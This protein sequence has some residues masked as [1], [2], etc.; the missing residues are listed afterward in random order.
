MVLLQADH[1]K[2][3]PYIISLENQGNPGDEDNTFCNDHLEPK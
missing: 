2:K 1:A 3:E